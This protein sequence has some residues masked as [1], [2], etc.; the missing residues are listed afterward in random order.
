MKKDE[1][2]RLLSPQKIGLISNMQH[3]HQQAS[4]SKEV[5]DKLK[6]PLRAHSKN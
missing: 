2:I 4:E 3:I 1:G 5:F 6:P